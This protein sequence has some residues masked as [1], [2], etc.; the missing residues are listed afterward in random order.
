MLLRDRREAGRELAARL[1]ERQRDGTLTD[2]IVLALP[3]GGVPVADEI[4]T[5][6]GAPLDVLVVRKIG[7]P[8]NPELGVGAVAG[9]APPLYDRRTLAALGLTEER[10]APTVARERTELRRREEL[11]RGGR[12]MPDVRGR[13]VVVVDDGL[14]TGVTARAALRAVRNMAPARV[15]MAVPVCAAE[16]AR[17]VAAEADELVY[18][19]QPRPFSSVGQWYLDF[20]QVGDDEVIRTLTAARTDADTG[21]DT[22]A[23]ADTGGGNGG[24]STDGG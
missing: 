2:P 24:T 5:A 14:A 13:T 6:L 11:Y 12:P 22:G 3:R 19:H 17:L 8:Y 4:A 7:A 23:G 20:D 21:A 15:V 9:E 18:L 16:A 1:A 10:L